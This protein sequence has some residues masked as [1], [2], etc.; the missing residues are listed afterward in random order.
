MV[1]SHMYYA[2]AVAIFMER[3]EITITKMGA[4][5]ILEPNGNRNPNRVIRLTCEWTLKV[6][7][8]LAPTFA[9]YE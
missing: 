3:I 5:P 4:Q 6:I 1:H 2:I 7:F 9:W 8:A